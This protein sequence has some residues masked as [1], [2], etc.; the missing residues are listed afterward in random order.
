MHVIREGFGL[1]ETDSILFASS[2]W[3]SAFSSEIMPLVVESKG[4][5]RAV[6]T[7]FAFKKFGKTVLI[8]PPF[9]TSCGLSFQLD[10]TKLVGVNSDVKRVMRAL[11]DYVNTKFPHAYIDIGFPPEVKDVQPFLQSG[12]SI[13]PSYTYRLNLSPS[14]DE[15]LAHFSPERRKN[16]RDAKSAAYRIEF[17]TN[18]QELIA[19]V[20]VTAERADLHYDLATLGRLIDSDF[21]YTVAI[22]QAEQLISTAVI[23]YDL[24]CAYYL[25]GG[26]V[27]NANTIGAGALVLWEAITKAKELKIPQF[28]FCGSSIPRIEK[29][30]RGFGG[31]LVPNFRVRKNNTLFDAMRSTKDKFFSH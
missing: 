2:Q 23:G 7:L 11:A 8:H 1:K 31:E 10:T 26:T 20:N 30:F 22:W 24:Q 13:H 15:L 6:L 17:D 27:K 21:T 28:D 16:I 9:A 3:A 12:F 25:V 5:T 14:E 29:F 19:L 4:N 18:P